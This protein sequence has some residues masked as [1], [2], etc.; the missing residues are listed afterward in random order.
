MNCIK[1]TKKYLTSFFL[2]IETRSNT[3]FFFFD[4]FEIKVSLKNLKNQKKKPFNKILPPH[5]KDFIKVLF[6]KIKLSFLIFSKMSNETY[7]QLSLSNSTI[8]GAISPRREISSP[9]PRLIVNANTH[10]SPDMQRFHEQ[11]F[12]YINI[13]PISFQNT[14]NSK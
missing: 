2:I 13:S 1:K 8:T 3:F 12:E 10:I 14:A 11:E 9:N 7:R 5:F 4:F 6:Y